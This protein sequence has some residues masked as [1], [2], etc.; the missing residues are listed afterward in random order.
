ML[1]LTDSHPNDQFQLLQRLFLKAVEV[2]WSVA[3]HTHRNILCRTR[4]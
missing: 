3:L 4:D 2:I 1:I